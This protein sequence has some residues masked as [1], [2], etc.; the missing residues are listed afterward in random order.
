MFKSNAKKPLKLKLWKV[1]NYEESYIGEIELSV[2][3]FVD[4]EVAMEYQGKMIKETFVQKEMFKVFD[5]SSASIGQ[6]SLKIIQFCSSSVPSSNSTPY[7]FQ[8]SC[9]TS[10]APPK[11][12]SSAKSICRSKSPKAK[13]SSGAP[14]R[15]K[16]TS[17]SSSGRR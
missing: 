12:P 14:A 17:F 10:Q 16:T 11:P 13:G 1:K 2:S 7:P 4:F 9:R 8:T 6:V 3:D 15:T 5:D